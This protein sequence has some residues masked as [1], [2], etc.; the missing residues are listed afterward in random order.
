MYALRKISSC[1]ISL[2]FTSYSTTIAHADFISIH[3][4]M[5]NMWKTRSPCLLL[6]W[7]DK[8]SVSHQ[9][10]SWCVCTYCHC[11]RELYSEKLVDEGWCI[12]SGVTHHKA[13]STSSF[14]NVKPY[15]G[16]D[17][18]LIGNGSSMP[19]KH[20]RAFVVKS[21]DGPLHLWNVLHVL[22]IGWKLLFIR[23][24]ASDLNAFVIIDEY[25]FCVK[26]K[27]SKTTIAN[28]LS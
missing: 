8:S 9:C 10:C 1:T 2:M 5:S 17:N 24:I 26:E 4:P 23:G 3:W 25:G 13:P 21:I 12:D 15:N 18:I 27:Q 20:T 6:C 16:M 22:G 11:T 19:I 7:L 28:S 14:A